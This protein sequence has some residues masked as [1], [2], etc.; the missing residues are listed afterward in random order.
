MKWYVNKNFSRPLNT[1][2]FFQEAETF[3]NEQ[4]FNTKDLKEIALKI[5]K[6]PKQNENRS[7]IV[8]LTQGEHPVL[9]ARDGAVEE[10]PV[11]KLPKESLVDTN[12]AGDAFTGGFLAQYIQ[13][14]PL[15]VCVK[16]GIWAATEIVQRSGCTY[17]GKA[18]FRP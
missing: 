5:C 13:G 2:N 10:F 12:G 3:A 4:N 6:L 18:T 14:Q 8:V 17:S 15:D 9:L 11:I 16:G 1:S 7:R